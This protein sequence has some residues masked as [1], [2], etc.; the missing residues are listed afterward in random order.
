[1]MRNFLRDDSDIDIILKYFF[2]YKRRPAKQGW[3]D[4]FAT[5]TFEEYLDIL[6]KPRILEGDLDNVSIHGFYVVQVIDIS[7]FD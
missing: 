7:K 1:M 4:E 5:K 3:N 6:S 2:K